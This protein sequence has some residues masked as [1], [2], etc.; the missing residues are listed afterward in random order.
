MGSHF[1]VSSQAGKGTCFEFEITLPITSSSPKHSS[2]KQHQEEGAL[3]QQLQGAANSL[4]GCHILVVEDNAINQIVVSELLE[5]AG[6]R[7]TLANHGQEALDKLK[8]QDFDGVLMDMHMPIMG[9]LEAT[10]HIRSNPQYDNLPVIALTA[11][12]TQEERK[13]CFECGMNDFI[14]KPVDAPLMINILVKWL[15]TEPNL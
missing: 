8:G 15:K 11:G 1:D 7:V 9:G 5:L 2:H 13:K 14:A 10:K 6:M 12:V 3:S 4:N